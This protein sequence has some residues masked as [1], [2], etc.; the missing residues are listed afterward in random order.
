MHYVSK[1]PLCF[2]TLFTDASTMR[3]LATQWTFEGM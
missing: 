3:G 1:A 2:E